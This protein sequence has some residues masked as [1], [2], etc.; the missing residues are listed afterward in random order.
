MINRHGVTYTLEPVD[1]NTYRLVGDFGK[2]WRYGARGKEINYDDLRFIDPS[3]GPFIGLG[4]FVD[5]REVIK[6]SASSSG[7]LLEVRRKRQR[8]EQDEQL[9]N[10]HSEVT[11]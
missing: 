11:V 5:G 2:F 8:K 3:G 10:L 9:P 7:I 1:K 6:I 4:S